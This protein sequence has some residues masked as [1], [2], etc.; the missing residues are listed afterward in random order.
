MRWTAEGYER[1]P[2]EV[3]EVS[4]EQAQSLVAHGMAEPAEEPAGKR[5]GADT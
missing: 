1:S 5:K 2:G 4:D 3:L